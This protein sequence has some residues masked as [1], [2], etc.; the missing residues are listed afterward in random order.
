MDN[1][2]L[3]SLARKRLDGKYSVVVLSLLLF[4][5]LGGCCS[6][7]AMAINASW[8]SSLLM[9]IVESLLMMGFVGIILNISR[10]KKVSLDD[11]FTKTDLFGKYIVITLLL[12]LVG[13]IIT[14]LGY[15]AF[16]SLIMVSLYHTEINL[17]LAIFLILFGLFLTIAII[18]VGIYLAIAFS[19]T[20]FIL[21]DEP[22]LSV[23]KVLEKSFDMMAD[24]ILEYFVLVLSFI[25]WAILGIFTFG[26]LYFWLI[27]YMLVTFA[28]F[29]D[30]IKKTYEETL[31]E[32]AKEAKKVV[33]VSSK[34]V[35]TKTPA[36]IKAPTK[37]AATK[38]TTAT[39]PTAKKVATKSTTAKPAV[40]K[41][42]TKTTSTA[43]KTTTKT[44]A[45]PA[46]KRVA[47]KTATKK[48]TTRTAAKKTTK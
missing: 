37:K 42:A 24:Y 7:V 8:T 25:G 14:L 27:P 9:F 48:T 32:E 6:F 33:T 40:K 5:V 43:K 16:K 38:K 4:M 36:A 20:Y 31:G 29:Y 28:I 18:M 34:P 22:K 45:K 21:Y 26:I 17:L 30:K 3:K 2:K 39:K 44:A 1:A 46:T 47:T 10:G 35:T 23:M 11:L 15:L 12:A 19:Q 41:A 13:F